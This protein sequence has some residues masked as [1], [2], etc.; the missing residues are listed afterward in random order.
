MVLGAFKSAKN[1]YFFLSGL[2]AVCPSVRLSVC[3]RPFACNNSAPSESVFVKL[4]RGHF[5]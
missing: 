1:D 4:F 5:Y 2:S 3:V